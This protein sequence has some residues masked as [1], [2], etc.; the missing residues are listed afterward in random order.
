MTELYLLSGFLGAGKT[1]L[2]QKLLREGFAGQKVALVEND[3]GAVSLDAKLLKSGGYTVQELRAGCICCTLNGNFVSALV[4][5]LRRV[6]PDVVLI[7]PS[8]V[9]KL[10]DIETLCHDHRLEA[11][12]V[13]KQ[14]ITVVDAANCASYC[15][16]FGAFFEDQVRCA[17]TLVFS[18]SDADTPQTENA[19]RLARKLNPHAACFA[20]GWDT[21]SAQDI[22]Q[23]APLAPAPRRPILVRRTP[24]ASPFSTVTISFDHAIDLKRLAAQLAKLQ[25]PALGTILR[26]KGVLQSEK[27]AVLLQFV[28]GKWS[29][30]QTALEGNEL[31]VIGKF[32]KEQ[33]IRDLFAAV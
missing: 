3:F 24:E 33:T 4:S 15:E 10:S 5:L 27:G 28:C 23:P 18:H 16:N 32:S 13:L 26:A 30:A 12:A 19:R 2:L 29:L 21:F 17:D 25:D 20:G 31:C 6:Q 22:L 7:E 9:A 11:L 8:G 1:T 14:K